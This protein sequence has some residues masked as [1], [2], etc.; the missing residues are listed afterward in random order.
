MKTWGIRARVLFLALAPGALILFALL[1]Y[2]TYARIAEVDA[3]LAR[4]GVSVAR[5]L[6][7]GAEFALFA[8]DRAALQR[9]ADAAAHEANVA[10]V[11][12]VDATGQELARSLP[13]EAGGD[14]E[15]IEFVHPV[16]QTP[17][18]AD[19][20]ERL[21][22]PAPAT[23]GQIVVT[24]SRRGADAEQRRLV[25]AGLILGLACMVGAVLLALLIGNG[26]VRPIRTLAGAMK[27]VGAGVRVRPI[28]V[29][30]GGELRTLG[31]GFN[32]MVARLQA[33]TDELQAR[34][35]A[36]TRELSAQ[37]D[38]AQEATAAKSRFIAAA[39]HDLRQP[40]H[41]IGMFTATLERRTADTEFQAVVAELTQAVAVMDRLFDAL[42]DV[43]RLEAGTLHVERKP[44]RLAGLFSQLEAE[45]LE[46]AAQKDLSLRFRPGSAI[47]ITDELLLHRLL[48]N[49]VANAIRYT[50]E[51][52]VLVAARRRGEHVRIEVRDSGIGIPAEHQEA[53]FREFYQVANPA[54]DRR[55]GLG[56]GLAIVARIARLLGTDVKVRSAPGKGSTFYLDQPLAARD[57]PTAPMRDEH[58]RRFRDARL[59]TA[60]LVVDDDP[61]AMA[62][63]AAL[64][65]TLGGRVARAANAGEAEAAMRAIG[66]TPVLVL[67]DL[68]LA[69]ERGGIALLR[70]LRA[71]AAGPMEGVLVSG[72]TRPETIQLARDAGLSLL[73]KPVSPARLRA[74]VTQFAASHR[75]PMTEH[76]T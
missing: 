48:G 28:G 29:S 72:D 52:S 8:G 55:L 53:I 36:A 46:A 63:S 23:M 69:D 13:D 16:V 75:A 31:E 22:A 30:G 51:G 24:M 59:D 76:S 32:E 73:H 10:S 25:V 67:C 1:V 2:F 49:L 71:I 57:A 4:Q 18:A 44:V 34:I 35:D 43:S 65:E 27:D 6:A 12:I 9:L 58:D 74:L 40:L 15:R 70:R 19:I 26:V 3:A 5:Q 17:M 54:R 20:P 37:R 38:A 64:L 62:G 50:H 56:L 11:R 60:I 68:W 42:L 21:H 61:I 66:A 41:A 47:V 39:S 33:G 14:A 45:H 7:S